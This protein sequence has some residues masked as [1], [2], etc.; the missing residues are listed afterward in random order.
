MKKKKILLLILCPFIFMILYCVA[1]DQYSHYEVQKANDKLRHNNA[2]GYYPAGEDDWLIKMYDGRNVTCDDYWKGV[3]CYDSIHFYHDFKY[4]I[5]L[6]VPEGFERI[7][8]K[9]DNTIMFANTTDSTFTISSF[10]LLKL[11]FW[12]RHTTTLNERYDIFSNRLQQD[13]TIN[14]LEW[15][16]TPECIEVRGRLYI[17]ADPRQSVNFI[18]KYINRGWKYDLL[19]MMLYNSNSEE[20]REIAEKIVRTFPDRP[21]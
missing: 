20:D 7:N 21:F 1:E 9:E 10:S 4:N 3:L 16:E 13:Y 2:F 12:K 15:K 8:E 5:D 18:H 6:L 14:V 17:K 19:A 11:N